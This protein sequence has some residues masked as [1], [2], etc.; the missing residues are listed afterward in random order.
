MAK[1]YAPNKQ[2][3]GISASVAF[4]N[5]RGETDNPELIKWF[6]RSGY[7]VEKAEAKEKAPDQDPLKEA[8]Q[9]P[10]KEPGKLDGMTVEQLTE[11]AKEHGIDIGN[12]TSVNGITKKITDA[13]KKG[14]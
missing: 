1:I 8:G 13:E 12:A 14:A 2:Y 3:T 10:A 4:A 5:G 7:T 9:V 6:E 11:Y